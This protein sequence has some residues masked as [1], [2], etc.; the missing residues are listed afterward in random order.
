M[1]K[2]TFL[3]N[4]T[5]SMN[6]QVLDVLPKPTCNIFHCASSKSQQL[7]VELL[8]HSATS[9][10]PCL[11][12][13]HLVLELWRNIRTHPTLDTRLSFVYLYVRFMLS[14]INNKKKYIYL[15]IFRSKNF[16][17]ISDISLT[18]TKK[19]EITWKDNMTLMPTLQSQVDLSRS[20]LTE[21]WN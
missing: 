19:E 14:S 11:A 16:F 8:K 17:K 4:S 21:F 5:N 1:V 18:T 6:G 13:G 2:V 7:L 3:T 9:A 15:Y 12:S 10:R 20:Y